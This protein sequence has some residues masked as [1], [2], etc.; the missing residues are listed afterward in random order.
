MRVKA[1]TSLWVDASEAQGLLDGYLADDRGER[2]AGRRVSIS[3]GSVTES[4]I[5]GP[6][7]AFQARFPLGLRAQTLTVEFAGDPYLEPSSLVREIDPSR[8]PV[9]LQLVMPTIVSLADT[10]I[11][12][13]VHAEHNGQPVRIA[14]DIVDA[15]TSEVLASATTGHDGWA[16]MAIE[17]DGLGRPGQHG[18]HAVF[19]GDASLAPSLARAEVL[20]V[21]A[22]RITL[23]AAPAVFFPEHTVR[24]EGLLSGTFAPLPGEE[25]ALE[26]GETTIGHA[27]TGRDGVFTA[28]I[29]GD[30]LPHAGRLSVVA[31][32]RS[33]T[34]ARSSC[35]SAPVSLRF[36]D[37]QPIDWRFVTAP[38]GVT[39][40]LLVVVFLLTR[41]RSRSPRE[42]HA[43][44]SAQVVE[45]GFR[46]SQV[47]MRA[48][49]RSEHFDISGIVVDAIEEQPVGG[50]AI[51]VSGPA[52]E[53]RELAGTDGTFF[54]G[55]FSRGPHT[56]LVEA[57]GYVAE[58]FPLM[59]PH[60]G[61][62]REATITIVQ[63][64]HRALEVYRA[65]ARP[66]L[67]RP[68]LWG[69]W[70]PRELA[71]HAVKTHPW[72]SDDVAALTS[73][74]ETLYYGSAVGAVADLERIR[75]LAAS[76][77]QSL[78]VHFTATSRDS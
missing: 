13:Q 26:A 16:S 8:L 7:G 47:S 1:R 4:V 32:Y 22:T 72:L 11:E 18:F 70:T 39:V 78:R 20:L 40:M 10:S 9:D 2:I 29:P 31:R 6:D 14:I 37:A 48:M 21:D 53:T 23:R 44:A 77:D 74:F 68:S 60:G 33:S 36:Q 35:V 69:L 49:R 59:L 17:T 55:P 15:G 25:I 65:A 51:T 24:F 43:R 76:L 38:A 64:R 28:E 61:N 19:A 75:R 58:S 62:F 46:P 54:M 42:A 52:D 50:A 5:T 3:S 12:A 56:V 34:T 66:L 27:T 67:P 57:A 41:Q 45:A 30:A 63:V 71:V 73:S